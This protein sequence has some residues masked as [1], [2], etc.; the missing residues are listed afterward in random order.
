MKRKLE[1]KLEH[2][3]PFMSRLITKQIDSEKNLFV[4]FGCDC[5]DGWY[6]LLRELCVEIT[7]V[8]KKRGLEPNIII[9]QV[10][11][12]YGTL[13]FYWFTSF[14][15]IETDRDEIDIVAMK[16]KEEI[17]NFINELHDIVSKYE[18][19]SESVCEKCGKKGKLRDDLRWTRTLC[20]QCYLEI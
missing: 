13:R 8:Y 19:K 9:S 1:L 7:E 16:E 2:E 18:D 4:M 20:K 6:E 11:E 14:N 12:K 17:S 5:D 10:K 15:T 3:F